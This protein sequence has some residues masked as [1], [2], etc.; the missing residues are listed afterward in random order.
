MRPQDIEVGATYRNRGAGRT[1]RTVVAIGPEHAPAVWHS[2]GP[3]PDEPG[4]LYEQDGRRH[5][6][7]LSSFAAWC[8]ARV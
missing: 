4:V 5:R 2:G 6:L 7:Y 1:R 3:P 8:G